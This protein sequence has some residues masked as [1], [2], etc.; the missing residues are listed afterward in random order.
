MN[1]KEKVSSKI[2]QGKSQ[3]W[4]MNIPLQL[5]KFLFTPPIMY[6]KD[7]SYRPSPEPEPSLPN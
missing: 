6:I 3:I 2:R 4:C 1:K 7:K 5:S